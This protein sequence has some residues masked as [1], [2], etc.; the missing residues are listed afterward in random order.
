MD[1]AYPPDAR[2][3]CDLA[4]NDPAGYYGLDL[5]NID[6][7]DVITPTEAGDLMSYATNRWVSEYT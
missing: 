2:D 5:L 7:L 3:V 1:G 6:A 4:L